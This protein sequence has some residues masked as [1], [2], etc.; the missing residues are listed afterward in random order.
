MTDAYHKLPLTF[1]I[2]R[3]QQD[4]ALLQ[5]GTWLEHINKGVHDG[6]WSALPLRA[7][8]GEAGNAVVVEMNPEC[9][10]ST[11]Y[12]KQSEY[13]QEVLA[14]FDCTLVSARLMSLKAGQ[15]IRRH[16]DMDLCFE[17]GCVRLHI[18]IQTHQDVTFLINDQPIHF[19]EG[20]C[21]YMNANYP[22]QVSNDSAIDRVHLVIDCL[23]N[24]WLKEL[25]VSTG[26][27]KTVVQHKYGNV[28]IT[29]DNVLEMIAQLE[30][31][32]SETAIEMV[33]KYRAIYEGRGAEATA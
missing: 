10:Q 32:G 16:T 28:S 11:P 5:N 6:G 24:D 33:N 27:E 23:V 17:D 22:H 3:L 4:L 26:Y 21:W 31:I 29:D 25:F 18:P 19:G 12:L 7:V 9:Y 13:L 1:D 14:S 8:D 30:Q 15:E 2:K 20:E